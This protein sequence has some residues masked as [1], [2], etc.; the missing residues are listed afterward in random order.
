MFGRGDMPLVPPIGSLG[1]EA[2]LPPPG[3]FG[4]FAFVPRCDFDAVEPVP[5]A[6]PGSVPI[7][8]EPIVSEPMVAGVMVRGI[9]PDVDPGMPLGLPVEP[10]PEP[11]M[12]PGLVDWAEATVARLSAAAAIAIILKRVIIFFSST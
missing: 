11:V 8:L 2:D 7:A 3:F 6:E 1:V 5:V 12:P 4:D 9:E 10:E